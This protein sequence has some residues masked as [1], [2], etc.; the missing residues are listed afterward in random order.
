VTEDDTFNKLRREKGFDELYDE[1]KRNNHNFKLWGS[2][3]Y[4]PPSNESLV[5]AARWTKDEWNQ[6]VLSKFNVS[7]KLGVSFMELR[8]ELTASYEKAMFDEFDLSQKIGWEAAK[9][10][11]TRKSIW[12]GHLN[13]KI[14][15]WSSKDYFAVGQQ[16]LPYLL[17]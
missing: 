13:K 16:V 14:K 10:T 9:K 3:G 6:E 12:D 2:S 4:S 17:K 11:N 8:T 1:I 5:L 7:S 15:G